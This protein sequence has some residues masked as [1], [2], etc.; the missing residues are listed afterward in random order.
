M[1]GQGEGQGGCKSKHLHPVGSKVGSLS[2]FRLICYAC[3]GFG[4]IFR[5]FSFNSLNY[6]PQTIEISDSNQ[7]PL[8]TIAKHGQAP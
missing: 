7:H 5:S 8:A 3:A 6:S 2:E 1:K 4:Q